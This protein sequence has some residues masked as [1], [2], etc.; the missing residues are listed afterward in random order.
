[1]AAQNVLRTTV[2]AALVIL[3]G[4][5]LL[6]NKLAELEAFSED[7]A[8]SRLA[9]FLADPD[10]MEQARGVLI[11]DKL[12]FRRPEHE[13][14]ESNSPPK[15]RQAHPREDVFIPTRTEQRPQFMQDKAAVPMD[16]DRAV[17][18]NIADNASRIPEK[19]GV[20]GRSATAKQTQSRNLKK[21]SGAIASRGSLGDISGFDKTSSGS[22]ST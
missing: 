20:D 3:A 6:V 18:G 11:D 7:R 17:M 12:Q 9:E 22:D 4:H 21:Q 10:M 5:Y 14:H 8:R 16:L 1:M 15:A 13:P 2:F 19:K